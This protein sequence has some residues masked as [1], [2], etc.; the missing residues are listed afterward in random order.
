MSK[1]YLPRENSSF[2]LINEKKLLQKLSIKSI[3]KSLDK[4]VNSDKDKFN[5]NIRITNQSTAGFE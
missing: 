1:R 4:L 5:E 3:N 2:T